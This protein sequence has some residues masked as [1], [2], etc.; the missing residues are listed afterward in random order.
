MRKK[1]GRTATTAG[2][3]VVLVASLL[4]ACG[5]V[6]EPTEAPRP[7]ARAAE[8]PHGEAPAATAPAPAN[9]G[10]ESSDPF[11]GVDPNA[12][13]TLRLIASIEERR[14]AKATG[15]APSS[16][17]PPAQPAAPVRAAAPASRSEAALVAV[18]ASPSEA[19]SS[20]AAQP[21]AAPSTAPAAA[22]SGN[23]SAAPQAIAEPRAASTAPPAAPAPGPTPSA[24]P[25]QPVA[26]RAEPAARAPA[27]NVE[28][29]L[30]PLERE[31][32]RFPAEALRSG[33]DS[34]RVIAQLTI[35]ADGR[36]TDVQ[37]VSSSPPGIFERESRR[38]L[39]AW[40]YEPPGRIVTTRVELVFRTE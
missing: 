39:F 13:P 8:R 30:R 14:P 36:V 32:P 7:P 10:A 6:P 17:P 4:S 2:F 21:L 12:D 24:T 33:V 25:A 31:A 34:G 18:A 29:P 23:P 20:P 5:K 26:A 27:P 3:A 22:S 16:A 1:F 9:T 11:A 40:R 37:I 35:G 19:A 15:R 28:A 38:A